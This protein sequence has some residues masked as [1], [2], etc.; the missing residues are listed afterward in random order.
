MFPRVEHERRIAQHC[1]TIDSS[2]TIST[3]GAEIPHTTC[4]IPHTSPC[5]P[6]LRNPY[7]SLLA[8]PIPIK[9]GK[10]VT[11][12]CSTGKGVIQGVYKPAGLI[13]TGLQGGYH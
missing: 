5:F 10:C 6:K 8:F 1:P 12:I 11:P 7:T 13:F 2:G 9:V 4:S 3:A